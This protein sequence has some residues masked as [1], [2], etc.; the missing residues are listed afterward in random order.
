MERVLRQRGIPVDTVV[1][2]DRLDDVS[3]PGDREWH[4]RQRREVAVGRWQAITPARYRNA[5]VQEPRARAWS[6]AVS[7][8]ASSAGALL[9][10]GTTGTGKT[11]TAFGA[12]R[13]IAETG[14]VWF[15]AA[16]L[17]SAQ[18]YGKLRPNGVPGSTE[19]ELRRLC[20]VPL[21]LLDD[22][23]AGKSSEWTEEVTYR[24]IDYRYVH[25]LPTVFTSN[26]PARDG[27]SPDLHSQLGERV[28]S[29]LAEMTTIVPMVGPDRRQR[30]AA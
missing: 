11:H 24:L 22:L 30:D 2:G 7:R 6:D 5:V 4:R 16:A 14:P 19:A 17:T 9:L 13:L 18:L 12:L 26:F 10:T 25:C 3:G 8:D 15:Q 28:T 21:L 27:T 1:G 23:G 29:R 20:A